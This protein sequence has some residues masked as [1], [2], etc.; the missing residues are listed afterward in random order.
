MTNQVIPAQA[1]E[2][3]AKAVFLSGYPEGRGVTWDPDSPVAQ[4]LKRDVTTAL[5]AAAPYMLQAAKAEAWEEGGRAATGTHDTGYPSRN[6][7][8]L[9][10]EGEK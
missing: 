7:Y 5:E 1:V 4:G 10:T 3:A 2:A 6:P 9:N 8:M